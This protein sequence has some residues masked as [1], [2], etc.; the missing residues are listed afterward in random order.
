M[1]IHVHSCALARMMDNTFILYSSSYLQINLYLSFF[2]FKLSEV[3]KN[4]F[5]TSNLHEN[6]SSLL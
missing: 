3:K 5:L 1:E 2:F 4:N 6:A